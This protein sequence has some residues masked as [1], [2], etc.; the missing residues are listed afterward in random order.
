MNINRPNNSCPNLT[1]EKENHTSPE[2][3]RYR[4]E[5]RFAAVTF[6]DNTYSVGSEYTVE[7]V[8]GKSTQSR[9][10]GLKDEN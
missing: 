2:G 5:G 8:F 10:K 7:N 6:V 4:R 9:L 1:L 3:G